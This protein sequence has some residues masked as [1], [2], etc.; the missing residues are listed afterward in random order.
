MLPQIINE[1]K[2]NT[3]KNNLFSKKYIISIISASANESRTSFFSPSNRAKRIVAVVKPFR[4]F[5]LDN[6]FWLEL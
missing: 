2:Q 6:F 1:Y 3:F 4:H 5:A